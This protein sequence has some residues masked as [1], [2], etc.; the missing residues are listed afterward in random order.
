MNTLK[1]LLP[2]LLSSLLAGCWLEDYAPP[3]KTTTVKRTNAGLC[4]KVTNPGDYRIATLGIKV[5]GAEKGFFREM[6]AL[7]IKKE[8]LCIPDSWYHF[9]QN[10][11]F[12]VDY[13]LRSPVKIDK[14]RFIIVVFRLINGEPY[15]LQPREGE[16]PDGDLEQEP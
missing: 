5:R 7:T 2:T 10:G 9:P 13:S 12:I 14:R 11:E 1:I 15:P 16:A 6:P 4:F 3:I 8:Q